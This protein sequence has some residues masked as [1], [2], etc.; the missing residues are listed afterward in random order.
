MTIR[1]YTRE[2]V[3]ALVEKMATSRDFAR[4]AEKLSGIFV[5][6]VYDCPG[7]LDKTTQWEFDSGKCIKWSYEEQPAPWTELRASAF[8]PNWVSRIS[9]PYEMLAKVNKG[10]MTPMR[11]LTSSSYQIEGKKVLILKMMKAVGAW[12]E[13]AASVPVVYE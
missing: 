7:G 12:N 10:E 4:E 11:A 8:H 9:C 1:Y 13:L 5:F 6:R 2:W 3:E